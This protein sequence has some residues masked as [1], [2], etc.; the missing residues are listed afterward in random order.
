[1]S[2]ALTRGDME[3]WAH[4]CQH[5][6]VLEPAA[7][8]GR[9]V[10]VA[11]LRFPGE[12]PGFGK[13]GRCLLPV[14]EQENGHRVR[15]GPPPAMSGFPDGSLGQGFAFEVILQ[16]MFSADRPIPSVR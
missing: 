6:C 8:Q 2:G 10:G 4:C 9:E 12:E 16:N 11:V 13:T 14:R 5:G 15:V 3:S 1:M 7:A